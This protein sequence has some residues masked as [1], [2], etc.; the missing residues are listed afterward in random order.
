MIQIYSFDPASLHRSGEAYDVRLVHRSLRGDTEGYSPDSG[1]PRLAVHQ[2]AWGWD[3]V[4]MTIDTSHVI[5]GIA[6]GAAPPG[7]PGPDISDYRNHLRE[8]AP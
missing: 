4:L 3:I 1:Q 5:A 8:S 7:E 6:F 2:R